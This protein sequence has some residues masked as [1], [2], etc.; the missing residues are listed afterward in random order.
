MKPEALQRTLDNV[1]KSV[2]KDVALAQPAMEEAKA[3]ISFFSLPAEI[4]DQIYALVLTRRRREKFNFWRGRCEIAKA[5]VRPFCLSGI[6]HGLAR[7]S[8][9]VRT[10]ARAVY[11]SQNSF[12]ICVN[13]GILN[14]N[15]H[16][17]KVVMER[18]ILPHGRLF[19]RL[20]IFFPRVNAIDPINHIWLNYHGESRP[21]PFDAS[22][23]PVPLL[24]QEMILSVCSI[25]SDKLPRAV[26]TVA[27]EPHGNGREQIAVLDMAKIIAE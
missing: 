21:S 20:S 23:G 13:E 26:V 3:R 11:Y 9:Q 22:W 19:R 2:E 24:T 15:L 17:L 12:E 8:H 6:G 4:R 5:P 27:C 25:Q 7:A 18:M 10:E 1:T 16:W 14:S